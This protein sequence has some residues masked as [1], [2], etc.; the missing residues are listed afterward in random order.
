VS[1]VSAHRLAWVEHDAGRKT[2][3]G[4]AKAGSVQWSEAGK[5]LPENLGDKPFEL[6]LGELK[7][8][9]ALAK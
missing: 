8:K 6:I 9:G 2:Q 3:D 1:W 7:T 4:P 5:H